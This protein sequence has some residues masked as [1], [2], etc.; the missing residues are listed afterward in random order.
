MDNVQKAQRTMLELLKAFDR[1][2]RR[3]K[4]T[5]W[6]D[7][8][9]LLGARRHGGFIPWDDDLDVS[10][11]LGDYKKFMQVAGKELPETIFLQHKRTDPGVPNHY[12]KLRHR[13]SWLVEVEEAGREVPYHQ[14]IFIDI[15]P[16][17]FVET[18]KVELYK[19]ILF[20]TKIFS[21]RYMHVDWAARM[22]IRLLE[23]FCQNEG[24]TVVAGGES[25]HWF[26]PYG[27]KHLFP[28]RQISFEG[29]EYPAPGDTDYVLEKI[30]GPDFMTLPPV[31]KRK[32]H[33]IKIYP[34]TPCPKE[35]EWKKRQP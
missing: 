32:A 28:L 25:L 11:P 13:G 16:V 29:G 20:V 34:H 19:K 5:Y 14:G 33:S 27:K 12:I 1:V 10:M 2:C 26:K 30:F 21:N 15:F 4:L 18:R 3:H 6:L 22:G 17:C 24:E 35:E 9:T 8:G 23:Q 7:F 31:E